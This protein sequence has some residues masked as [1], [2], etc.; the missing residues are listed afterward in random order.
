MASLPTSSVVSG[1]LL[2]KLVLE[3]VTSYPLLLATRVLDFRAC[4]GVVCVWGGELSCVCCGESGILGQCSLES[5]FSPRT[6]SS[7]PELRGRGKT[8]DLLLVAGP[9]VQ[10]LMGDFQV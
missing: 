10:K 9:K 5:E 6:M 1:G 2:S 4:N 8:D 7:L 3:M